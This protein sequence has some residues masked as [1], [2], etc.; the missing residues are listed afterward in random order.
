M[1]ATLR[2]FRLVTLN[3]NENKNKDIN[4]LHK[5]FINKDIEECYDLITNFENTNDIITKKKYSKYSNINI[6]RNCLLTEPLFNME[7]ILSESNKVFEN[8]NN[9]NINMLRMWCV[10]SYEYFINNI[11]VL[12]DMLNIFK[13]LTQ[14]LIN[15]V[16][17]YNDISFNKIFVEKFITYIYELFIDDTDIIIK[18]NN[19]LEYFEEMLLQCNND[20]LL[21]ELI[22]ILRLECSVNKEIKDEIEEIKKVKTIKIIKIE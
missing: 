8:G 3:I 6:N 22:L 20:K 18:K 14:L 7:Y 13:L 17:K 4:Y 21:E 2:K 5:Q 15:L 11:M 16:N 12:D 19:I 1:A 9:A 10:K